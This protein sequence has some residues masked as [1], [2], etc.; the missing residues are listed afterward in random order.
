[1]KISKKKFEKIYDNQV[2]KI[3]R[4]VFLKVGSIDIAQD[5]TSQTFI[6]AWK[7]A[8]A[9]LDIKN[10]NAY[11]F[12]IARREIAGHYRQ[13]SKIK[14]VSAE[15]VEIVSEENIEQNQ[16]IQMEFEAV[17][18]SLTQL[19]E[20]HQNVLLW[21]YVDGRSVKEIAQLLG[22]EPNAVRVM[23]HRALKSLRVVIDQ[24]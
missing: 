3:Y 19:K 12:Q 15:S 13:A 8:K 10:P 6:K 2:G 9:G 1:M 5:L 22:K 7:K 14:I 24:G 20:D 21:R 4:F 23:I 18:T 11:I 16:G 17:R